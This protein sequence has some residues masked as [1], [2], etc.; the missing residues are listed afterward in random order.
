MALID[1]LFPKHYTHVESGA[2]II[3][4]TLVL[5]TWYLHVY[6]T[7][8]NLLLPI[9]LSVCLSDKARHSSPSLPLKLLPG[10]KR[11]CCVHLVI[12]KYEK[13]VEGWD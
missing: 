4:G 5:I 13:K 2:G 6:C 8:K 12:H 10:K 3:I 9:C 7:L 11:N 1:N